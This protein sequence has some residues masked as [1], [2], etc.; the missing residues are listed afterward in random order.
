MLYCDCCSPRLLT[1]AVTNPWR[2]V[3]AS[4]PLTLTKERCSSSVE[5]VLVGTS[6]DGTACMEHIMCIIKWHII[7]NNDPQSQQKGSDH[8][9][10][11]AHK[12][13][14]Q[15]VSPAY[16][17]D[18]SLH[19]HDHALKAYTRSSHWN[20][21]LCVA[22]LVPRHE[23][24]PGHEA[25]NS[26]A[27]LLIVSKRTDLIHYGMVNCSEVSKNLKITTWHN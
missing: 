11:Q 4:W 9:L 5:W 23:E 10:H 3:L 14:I 18:Q 19:H 2:N 24:G 7:C 12:I 1:S 15:T 26:A 25:S 6:E 16:S 20:P 17:L 27:S 13:L 21:Y 8:Y 22:E